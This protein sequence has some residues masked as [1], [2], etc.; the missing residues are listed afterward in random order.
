MAVDNLDRAINSF[1]GVCIDQRVHAAGHRVALDGLVA[2]A[3][4]HTGN[5]ISGEVIAVV[6]LHALANLEDIGLGVLGDFPAFQQ[7]ALESGVVVVLHQI[8][9][10]AARD[11]GDLRPVI[12]ARIF[13]AANFLLDANSAA[14]LGMGAGF[15]G[16]GLP[17]QRVGACSGGAESAGQR[18]EFP[19]GNFRAVLALMLGLLKNMSGNLALVGF[20]ELHWVPP[21]Y[22]VVSV[23]QM[24]RILFFCALPDVSP[25]NEG[26]VVTHIAARQRQ[27][28]PYCDTSRDIDANS[29]SVIAAQWTTGMSPAV[30]RYPHKRFLNRF[31]LSSAF[32]W[33]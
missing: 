29:Y 12:G 28:C 27:S 21:W 17:E 4:D 10:P 23:G 15:R 26:A 32:D 13:Q 7:L 6:P 3:S 20:V 22:P 25:R 30:Q 16:S 14:H 19:T 1:L 24:T 33:M 31:P 5:I 8:F 11:I 9:Q 2:P 18:D